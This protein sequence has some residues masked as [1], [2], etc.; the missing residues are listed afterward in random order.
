MNQTNKYTVY[1]RCF[2]SVNARKLNADGNGNA[3]TFSESTEQRGCKRCVNRCPIL[4]LWRI[5]I[6]WGTG[7][8][9]L[10]PLCISIAVIYQLFKSFFRFTFTFSQTKQRFSKSEHRRLIFEEMQYRK[11]R[12]AD[13]HQLCAKC[14]LFGKSVERNQNCTLDKHCVAEDQWLSKVIAFKY[15]ESFVK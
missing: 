13:M 7:A 1:F 15:C 9:I 14:T 5:A 3:D 11:Q 12:T 6:Q 10:F 8:T 2:A 4:D